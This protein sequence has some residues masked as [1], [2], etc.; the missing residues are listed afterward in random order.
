[1]SGKNPNRRNQRTLAVALFMVLS[2][3]VAVGFWE[4]VIR[5]PQPVQ[6][7]PNNPL[8]AGAQRAEIIR[9]LKEI[10]ENQQAMLDV[11]KSGEMKVVVEEEKPVPPTPPAPTPN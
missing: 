6:A 9:L 10:N 1:M 8:D 2:A 5:E 7:A 3:I 11:L 4:A